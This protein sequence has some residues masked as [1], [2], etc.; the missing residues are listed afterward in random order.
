MTKNNQLE[1]LLKRLQKKPNGCWEYQ[2][3]LTSRGYGNIRVDGT[4]YLAHRYSYIVHIGEIPKG[5]L[6][7]HS[8]DNPPCCNPAHLWLGTQSENMKDMVKKGRTNLLYGEDA[9]SAKLT[10]REVLEM[11]ELFKSGHFTSVDLSRIY[12]V[13]IRTA[14]DAVN[15]KTWRHV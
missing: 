8:C 9:T 11:R 13:G 4:N 10:E 5:M 15:R 7:C 1:P 2:G 3:A 12:G 14:R 6:V